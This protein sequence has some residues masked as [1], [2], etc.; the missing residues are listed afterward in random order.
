MDKIKFYNIFFNKIELHQFEN[1][2]KVI[3]IWNK[4][5]IISYNS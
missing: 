5:L 1:Y 3:T 2:I 4:N